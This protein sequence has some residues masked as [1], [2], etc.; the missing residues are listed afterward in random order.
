MEIFKKFVENSNFSVFGTFIKYNREVLPISREEK[1]ERMFAR[2]CTKVIKNKCRDYIRSRKYINDR[3]M[4]MSNIASSIEP[5]T[6]DIH[7]VSPIAF[8]DEMILI[9]HE[10]LR[11]ALNK[12]NEEQFR[13]IM[14]YYFLDMNDR[15][16]AELLKVSKT[17]AWEKRKRALQSLKTTIAGQ[18]YE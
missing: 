5:F 17:G 7:F 6:V 2:Y 8:G 18:R 4:S 12:L 11:D 14:Y 9:E 1:I 15:E 13:I 3:E 16:I 10:E